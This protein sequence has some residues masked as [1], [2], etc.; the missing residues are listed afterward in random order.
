MLGFWSQPRS[1]NYLK[2]Q[3]LV[4]GT[5]IMATT[6]GACGSDGP[7]DGD[8]SAASR[9]T[10]VTTGLVAEDIHTSPDN[11]STLLWVDQFAGPLEAASEVE[12]YASLQDMAR[13]ADAVLVGRVSKIEL[14]RVI[15]R[16]DGVPPVPFAN[17][18]IMVEDDLSG[19]LNGAKLLTVEIPFHAT[20]PDLEAAI[21]AAIDDDIAREAS[22][23]RELAEA[24]DDEAIAQAFRDHMDGALEFTI[25]SMRVE[26]ADARS[27]F[28]LREVGELSGLP[29]EFRPDAGT[30]RFVNG[31]G[32]ISQVDGRAVVP[33]RVYGSE[34]P[35][36]VEVHE[37]D[38]EVVLDRTRGALSR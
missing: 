4:W 17:F 1:R 11:G 24:T 20:S 36:A 32:L 16:G 23:D 30:F 31:S 33:M 2:S 22:T 38:F 6:L 15:P 29:E 12:H 25:E 28:F 27:I 9:T 19:T 8:E 34:D 26:D 13:H 21:D 3:R 14:G 37:A 18:S 5:L 7:H 10:I 35:I